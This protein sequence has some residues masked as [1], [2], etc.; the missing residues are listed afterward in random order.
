VRPAGSDEPRR[1]RRRKKDNDL[2]DERSVE[3]L[4]N[5][6]TSVEVDVLGTSMIFRYCD[7]LI[8]GAGSRAHAWRG[9]D[10]GSGGGYHRMSL[11][12]GPGKVHGNDGVVGR[13]PHQ[14]APDRAGD[15]TFNLVSGTTSEPGRY[16]KSL[17][18]A[19]WR[20]GT[21]GASLRTGDG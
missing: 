4:T 12:V 1:L 3:G 21:P 11:C 14:Q 15:R 2:V 20:A 17:W 9:I 6:I 8:N 18:G 5:E 16:V 13:T 10:E 7:Q 19:P